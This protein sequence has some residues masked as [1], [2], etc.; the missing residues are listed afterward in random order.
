MGDMSD[1]DASEQ[2]RIRDE[3]MAISNIIDG[4]SL[5]DLFPQFLPR[6]LEQ[7]VPESVESLPSARLSGMPTV[8]A[9]ML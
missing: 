8:S 5:S 7:T 6:F 1:G 4:G 9:V 2:E 3:V